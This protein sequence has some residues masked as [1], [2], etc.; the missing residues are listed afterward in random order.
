MYF[1]TTALN[2]IADHIKLSD[3]PSYDIHSRGVKP[4][5]LQD[6]ATGNEYEILPQSRRC[7]QI[8][9][10]L[11][12][13]NSHIIKQSS[14]KNEKMGKLT[15]SRNL[16]QRFIPWKNRSRRRRPRGGRRQADL[17]RD[18]ARN[19]GGGARAWG[20]RGWC[21]RA[22]GRRCRWLVETSEFGA[23]RGGVARRWGIA[24]AFARPG[25]TAG[26]KAHTTIRLGTSYP[27]RDRFFFPN[28]I[29][30]FSQITQ[31]LD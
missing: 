4:Q 26:S 24:W 17:R 15:T 28:H 5:S 16:F 29:D 8:N 19:S 2:L 21:G 9:H 14:C 7:Y 25:E 22:R 23:R 20:R 3:N 13:T 11:I 1:S 10:H 18:G 31:I 6:I 12:R 27:S 30:F